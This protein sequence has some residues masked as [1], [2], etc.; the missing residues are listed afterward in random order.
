[1]TRLS[2]LAGAFAAL[3]SP[4]PGTAV[5]SP[6]SNLK[7][8]LNRAM[9]GA[10]SQSG[11]F[12]A[13]A[14]TGKTLYS[15]RGGTARILASNTKLFTSAAV[16]AR[17]GPGS[18]L[19]TSLIGKG[20]LQPNGTWKGSV[21]LRGGGDPTFGSSSFA[22]ANYG[23][24]ASVEVLAARLRKAGFKAVTG[25]VVGDESAFDSRRGGPSSGYGTS[26]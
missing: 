4:F 22:R 7:R 3:L 20:S 8:T 12:V 23:T 21:Y 5:A 1:M 19:A 14:K 9:S 26:T 18:S 16:L 11:A 24:S 13:D 2:L 25:S 15:R 17:Y 10:G 6:A